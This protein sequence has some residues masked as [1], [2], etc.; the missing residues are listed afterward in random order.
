MKNLNVPLSEI[1]SARI[2]QA[3]RRYWND[4]DGFSLPP[5][6]AEEAVAEYDTER[7][8]KLDEENP[9]IWKSIDPIFADRY[10]HLQAPVNDQRRNNL[11]APR[12]LITQGINDAVHP[13]G[14]AHTSAILR[15]SGGPEPDW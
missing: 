5:M 1:A 4:Q 14:A 8:K 2:N 10:R 9:T 7:I 12:P 15:S 13:R 11:R 3:L 6:K